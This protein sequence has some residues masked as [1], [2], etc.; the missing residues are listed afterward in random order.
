MLAST[1]CTTTAT[2]LITG[3]FIT[4][5]ATTTGSYCPLITVDPVNYD[6]GDDD[7][8]YGDLGPTVKTTYSASVI[9]EKTPYRV[10]SGYVT[11][12]KT[13]YSIPP[14]KSI[15]K[16]K[17]AGTSAIIIPSSVGSYISIT[18]TNIKTSSTSYEKATTTV[19]PSS[20][21]TSSKKTS[22]KTTSSKSTSSASKTTTSYPTNTAINTGEG[23]CFVDRSGYLSFSLDEARQGIKSFCSSNYVLD[24]DNTIGQADAVEEDGYNVVVSAKWAADQSGCDDKDSFT[25]AD[26]DDSFGDCLDAWNTD[27]FCEDQHGDAEDS[28]GG[29]YVL[30][31]PVGCVLFS[32][33]AYDT[34]SLALMARPN[35]G[36]AL[37]GPPAM[38]ITHMGDEPIWEHGNKTSGSA[39]WST[40]KDTSSDHPK[41]FSVAEVGKFLNGS[42]KAA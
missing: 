35:S 8:V 27:F 28:Y 17:L 12:D 21:T 36:V 40:S 26:D 22:S 16:T 32:L 23:Y 38:N 5:T 19:F 7:N 37:L 41:L 6:L 42:S 10:S 29:A 25:F 24:P 39:A 11:I 33:Y 30:D 18:L 31:S 2:E 15:S 4:A 20:K 13:A 9:V 34:S 1:S 3:C 14:V